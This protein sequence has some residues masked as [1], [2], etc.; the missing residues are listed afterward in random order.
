MAKYGRLDA[1]N[2]LPGA[3]IEQIIK[4][5]VVMIPGGPFCV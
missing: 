2:G 1:G 5:S 4:Y 3:A